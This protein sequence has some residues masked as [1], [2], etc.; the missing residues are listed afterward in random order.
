M[1][2]VPALGGELLIPD[3]FEPGGG[4][5]R[6]SIHFWMGDRRMMRAFNDAGFNAVHYQSRLGGRSNQFRQP[7]VDDPALFDRILHDIEGVTRR[8]CSSAPLTTET[9]ALSAFSAGYAAV[10]EILRNP[11]WYQRIG[12]LIMA[13]TIYADWVSDAVRVP[14]LDQMVDFMRFA[15][16]AARGERAMTVTHTDYDTDH[17]GYCS[18][19]K[20]ADLLLAA[21]GGSREPATEPIGTC[22]RPTSRCDVGGFHL[23]HYADAD[24]LYHLGL[25]SELWRIL[26]LGL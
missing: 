9:V 15:Q 5:F 13:D 24:H 23:L 2:I 12:S 3:G 26:G 8:E 17:A 4:P 14:R 21:V 22:R 10:R 18:T 1:K 11:I 6:V 7:F 19:R 25:I 16:A 20:T